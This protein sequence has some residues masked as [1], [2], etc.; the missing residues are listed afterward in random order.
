MPEAKKLAAAICL[1]RRFFD[2]GTGA[3]RGWYSL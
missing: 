1:L 2:K 3:R